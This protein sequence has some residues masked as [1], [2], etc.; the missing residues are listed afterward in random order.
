MSTN[1]TLYWIS[2]PRHFLMASGMAVGE[3]DVSDS[4]LLLTSDFDYVDG[5]ETVLNLWS[6]SPFSSTDIVRPNRRSQSVLVNR[7]QNIVTNA[8]FRRMAHRAKYSEIRSFT[9]GTNPAAHAFLHEI[10]RHS[11]TTKRILVE[12][13]GI[14]YNNQPIGDSGSGES[15][16]KGRLM[17]GR[18]LYG[19]AWAAVKMNGIS[20]VVDEIHMMNPELVRK[21]WASITPVKLSSD[22]LLCLSDTDLPEIYLSLFDCDF[23]EFATIEVAMI[24][25]RSDGLL[26]DPESYVKTINSLLEVVRKRGFKVALKYHPKEPIPDYLGLRDRTDIVEIPRDLPMELL[27]LVSSDRLKLVLGDTSTAL[28]SAPWILPNC[29]VVSFV[30]MVNKL[31]ELIYSD[32][33]SFGVE[34]MDS[35]HNLEEMLPR[36]VGL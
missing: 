35:E 25:S 31:P 36:T 3:N 11:P 19:R 6:D 29:K 26:G 1:N 4:D 8:R 30:N 34:L 24:L 18:L 2:T 33:G 7:I 10:K 15:Y 13:G 5:I 20:E 22:H 23:Q 9:G 28:L 27:F 32:F 17:A 16:P 12:D 14:Y 21:D